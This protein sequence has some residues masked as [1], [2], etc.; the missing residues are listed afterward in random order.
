[1][2]KDVGYPKGRA[3]SSVISVVPMP[4]HKTSV[5]RKGKRKP[6]RK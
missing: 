4:R 3:Q 5:K 2:P 6:T 1:M